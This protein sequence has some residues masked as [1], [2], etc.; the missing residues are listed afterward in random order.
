[1]LDGTGDSSIEKLEAKVKIA[2]AAGATVSGRYVTLPTDL[3]VEN[4]RKR[5]AQLKAAGRPAREVPESILRETHKAVSRTLVAAVERGTYDDVEL[6]DTTVFGKS[7]KVMSA[8][9]TNMTV[10]NEELW[11]RFKAKA[12]E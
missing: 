9:G 5:A 10:H 11:E 4:N 8:V 12:N 2:R 3:A 7:V 6:W 1:M